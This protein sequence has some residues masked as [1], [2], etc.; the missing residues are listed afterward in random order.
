[1]KDK[2]IEAKNIRKKFGNSLAL[3]DISF[4]I[5][6]GQIFGFLGP[7]G[8][9][10]TTTINILTGQLVADDG[11]VEILD[12]DSRKL[13]SQELS[14]IGLVSDTSGFL[15]KC[16]FITICFFMANTTVLISLILMCLLKRVK[17]YDD[18]KKIAGKLS[19][20]MKQRMLLARALINKPKI[21]FLDEPTSGLRSYYLAYYS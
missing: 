13:S 11:D 1:M 8:S 3:V 15:K 5:E 21:L 14:Q 6:E 9:G 10:K 20:G 16:L 4:S 12:Q 7:S 18:R 19:T 17:L 2:I